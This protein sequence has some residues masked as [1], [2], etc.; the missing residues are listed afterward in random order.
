MRGKH[1]SGESSWW[2]LKLGLVYTLLL[3]VRCRLRADAGLRGAM[4]TLL[5]PSPAALS[6]T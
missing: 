2:L 1:L 4:S 6:S 5:L 3:C